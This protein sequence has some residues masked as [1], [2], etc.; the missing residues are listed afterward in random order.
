[1][2]QPTSTPEIPFLDL[3]RE[4]QRLRVSIE[5]AIHRVLERG[6]FILGPE[7]EALELEFARACQVSCAV[8]VGSGTDAIALSLR[9]RG[10]GPGDDV[11]TVSH[12]AV[13]TV[14]AIRSA[15]ARPV[16]VDIDASLNIDPV[17]AERAITPATKAI[18]A[19]HLYGLPADMAALSELARRKGLVLIEDAA[20]AQGATIDGRHV[21]GL[22]DIGAFSL[23]PTK[24]LGAYGDGGMVVCRGADDAARVKQLRQYGWGETRYLSEIEGVNSRMDE[25][26]AAIVRAKLTTFDADQ[27]ARQEH[28][29]AYLEGLAGLPI[30]LPQSRPGVKHAY[31]LFVV[32]TA[33]RD[34]LREHLRQRGISTAIHYP[35]AV[36]QQPP[37][38][39]L[40]HSGLANTE[41]AVKEILSLPMYPDLS[42]SE[43]Q[44]VV[45]AI[46][47]FFRG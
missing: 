45:D 37:Y 3:R 16:L 43:R 2:G 24:N 28:A 29:S 47:E 18:V 33:E 20:Q 6:S 46:R 38:R 40:G 41:Q 32:R 1:V 39:N 36:H 12:T 23:Y 34:R 42:S 9:A 27:R 21:G 14:A 44:R 5:G 25:I 31:H 30:S 8:A 35:Y 19:V 22:G 10:I 7:N 4:Y 26:Q 11:I 17:A 15:G 13:A